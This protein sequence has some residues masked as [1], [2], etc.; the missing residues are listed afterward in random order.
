MAISEQAKYMLEDWGDANSRKIRVVPGQAAIVVVVSSTHRQ[1]MFRSSASSR[2]TKPRR[3]L[4]KCNIDAY[5]STSMNKL[6]IYMC[7][8]DEDDC[9]VLVKTM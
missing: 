8:R 2:W 6:G 4:Y 3:E 5:F 1:H 7:I 9:Y